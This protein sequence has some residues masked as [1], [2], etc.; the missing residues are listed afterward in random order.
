MDDRDG[1]VVPNESSLIASLKC[2]LE[3][4]TTNVRG[5]AG[6]IIVNASASNKHAA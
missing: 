3:D 5:F 1:T 2:A 6:V 4:A